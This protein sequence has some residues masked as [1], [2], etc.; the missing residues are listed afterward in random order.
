MG[1][2]STRHRIGCCLPS[3]GCKNTRRPRIAGVVIL[4]NKTIFMLQ[5]LRKVLRHANPHCPL[6]AQH[7]QAPPGNPKEGFVV[8]FLG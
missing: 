6:L 4:E 1:N 2:F 7:V 5:L 3:K 8:I